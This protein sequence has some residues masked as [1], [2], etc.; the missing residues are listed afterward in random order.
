MSNPL[1]V[2]LD[3]AIAAIPAKHPVRAEIAEALAKRAEATERA[4]RAWVTMRANREAAS[5]ALQ[6]QPTGK[7]KSP[8]LKAPAQTG[9]VQDKATPAKSAKS[10]KVKM[11]LTASNKMRSAR[12]PASPASH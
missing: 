7:G 3:K 5:A 2:L 8:A 1:Q 12:K 11:Q 4:N 10:A 9:P 6:P